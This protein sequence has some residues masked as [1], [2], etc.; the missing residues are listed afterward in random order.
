[1]RAGSPG[2]N[3]GDENLIRRRALADE[4]KVEVTFTVPTL[5]H[6]EPISVLGDFNGWDDA[7]TVMTPVNDN[8][9][10]AT[11]V[12]HEQRRY[13]FRY[14]DARGRWFN[15]EEADDYVDSPTGAINGVL[16]T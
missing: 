5:G 14:R 16:L 7:A 3:S 11:V 15:D 8:E 13:E 1:V 4:T 2:K 6:P 12:L 10:T 9:L